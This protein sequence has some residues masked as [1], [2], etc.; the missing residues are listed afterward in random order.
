MPSVP[1]RV[2]VKATTSE[3]LGFVGRQDPV[4]ASTALTS[5]PTGI[6][7]TGGQTVYFEGL[8]ATGP[9][10]GSF[11]L[12]TTGCCISRG[13]AIASGGRKP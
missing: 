8:Q 1:D 4:A 13:D 11:A 7:P 10:D 5:G 9:N 2:C 6:T 12:Q 3:R